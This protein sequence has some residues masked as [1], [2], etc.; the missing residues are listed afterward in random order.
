MLDNK[1]L[2]LKLNDTE[3]SLEYT[4]PDR[5]IAKA[6]VYDEKINALE[7]L[8]CFLYNNTIQPCSYY[9]ARVN[10]LFKS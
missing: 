5:N 4:D 9:R 6:I 1:E 3:W 7:T 10:Y 2:I 8:I